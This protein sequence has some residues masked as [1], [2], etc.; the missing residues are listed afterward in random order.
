VSN[1]S[2]N[3]LAIDCGNSSVRVT[4]GQFDGSRI[5][6]RLIH[7]IEQ[8][9]VFFSGLYYWDILFLYQHLKIGLTK[10]YAEC[11]RIDSAAISTWGI[12]FA[13]SNSENYLLANPLSYR[14]TLGKQALDKL[15]EEQRRFNFFNSGIQCDKINTLYQI[16]GFRERF[17]RTFGQAV[18]LLLI[19]DLLNYLFT[20]MACTEPTILST[21]QLYDVQKGRYA[22][23]IFNA[24]DIE[25]GL[26]PELKKHGDARGVLKA[27]IADELGINIFPF[28]TIPS[29]DTAAAVTS[30]YP[31][32]TDEEPLFISSG[33]WSLIGTELKEPIV[34]EAVYNSD[35]TNEGGILGTITFLKNSAG[36]YIARRLYDECFPGNDISW[37]EVV[38]KV[39]VMESP[40]LL[41]DPNGDE[42][43]NPP[44]M[45]ETILKKIG[46]KPPD[47]FFLFRLVYDS[48][49][50][51]YKHAIEEIER[52]R[53]KIYKALYI[54]GGG[55]RNNLLNKITSR[56][57][58]KTV[59]AGPDEATSI[60]NIGAQ[61]LHNGM[62]DSLS[63][64]RKIIKESIQIAVY[65]D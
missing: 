44:N 45:K 53:G 42:F 15:T 38:K 41:F 21:S 65:H 46:V 48:L 34:N 27:E 56:T 12:D 6:T 16:I 28:V 22:E 60:G 63:D 3:L 8:K 64:I 1:K 7:Y 4:L 61:L 51:S 23:D 52:I 19:P 33:T 35:F 9:E 2:L 57:T 18:K 24:F 26:F 43:F 49:A 36:L 14:N 30:I 59:Y 29:H 62:A 50:C 5:Q 32:E 39:S 37:D 31:R 11:G 25:K 40:G 54:V 47:D 13:L 10:A 17:P 55:S 20:G 58:G